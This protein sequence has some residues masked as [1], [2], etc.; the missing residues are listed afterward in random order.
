MR[1]ILIGLALVVVSVASLAAQQLPDAVVIPSLPP[2]AL[3]H[4][5]SA[6]VPYPTIQYVVRRGPDGQPLIVRG[7][8][9][10]TD[11]SGSAPI[12]FWANITVCAAGCT[13][14]N[15]GENVQAAIDA[16]TNGDSVLLQTGITYVTTAT[17]VPLRLRQKPSCT[18]EA[19]FTTI[20][21]GV[22]STGGLISLSSF[23]AE[24]IRITMAYASTLAKLMPSVANDPAIRTVR[25]NETGAGCSASPCLGNY[26]KLQWL[27]VIPQAFGGLNMIE[28]GSYRDDIGD[29][30]NHQNTKAKIPQFHTLDQM[31]IRGDPVRG[32]HRCLSISSGNFRVSNSY[33]PYCKTM[34]NDGQ[35]IMICNTNGPGTIVN[36]YIEPSTE[37]T[38]TCGLDPIARQSIN[39]AA[40]PAP[41]STVFT[42]ASTPVDLELLQW[43]MVPCSG[44]DKTT[45]VTAISTNQL[46]VSPALPCTPPAGTAVKWSLQVADVTFMYNLYE[47]PLTMRDP[48]VA[49]VGTPTCQ[50]FGSGGS[51]ADGTYYFKLG[52]L[53]WVMQNQEVESTASAETSCTVT[54]GG[55]DGRIQVSWGAVANVT[56]ANQGAYRVYVGTSAGAENL[57]FT[58]VAPTVTYNYAST[59]SG[60][61]GTPPTSG[62]KWSVKNLFE[63]KSCI[64][65]LAKFNKFMHNWGAQQPGDPILLSVLN[66]DS[67]NVSAV[68]RDSTFEYNWIYG[69]PSFLN[70]ST[71]STT[72]T[73]SGIMERVV[74]R[75]NLAENLGTTLWGDIA[76]WGNRSTIQI[77]GGGGTPIIGDVAAKNLT[78]DHNTMIQDSGNAP[79]FFAY[80]SGAVQDTAQDMTYT[81]NIQRAMS[82]LGIVSTVS[83][84]ESNSAPGTVGW[85]TSTSGVRTYGSNI[86]QGA[87][88]CTPTG[89]I[90]PNEATFQAQFVS[91]GG[92]NFRC[93]SGQTCFNGATAGSTYPHIGAD[94][95]TI[96][97]GTAPALSGDCSGTNCLGTGGSPLQPTTSLYNWAKGAVLDGTIALTTGT[98]KVMIANS[99]Y[100]FDPDHTFI[101]TGG[102]AD[103]VD[104]RLTGTTDQTLSSRVIGVDNAGDLAYFD[105]A[106]VTFAAVP[107]S[108]TATHLIIYN[109]TGTPTTSRLIA[110]IAI[111]H[112][113]DGSSITVTWPSPATGGV[114]VIR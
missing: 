74:V 72:G 44:V 97:A 25:T 106:D 104:A 54:G 6:S 22:N 53:H 58:V 75:H 108:Q 67:R 33:F 24:N 85:E 28:L 113:S 14:T 78:I 36:N 4:W 76:T 39:I 55:N 99:T 50:A 12:M 57:F 56:A 100:V 5:G 64:R 68:I 7:G 35:A 83:P 70:I 23:P 49:T 38:I 73:P 90:C 42:L 47:R 105:A 91:Y 61:S 93:A 103:P 89:T 59:G 112:I 52:A 62:N 84:S 111:N 79:L 43:V 30:P 31:I 41:T 88:P 34:Q 29:E 86:S 63:W 16:A 19:C 17:G 46:T 94:I 40:S 101:D 21:T 2:N 66:D 9:K 87:S 92:N 60:T 32:Q 81:N 69:A 48:I 1:R 114:L 27:E 71:S 3:A 11:A 109:D 107:S 10:Y 98:K 82:Y 110:R 65:C 26:W 102:A 37:G 77:T 20:R 95:D 13:F 45:Q 96:M 80:G 8:W 18:G 15:S 51:L